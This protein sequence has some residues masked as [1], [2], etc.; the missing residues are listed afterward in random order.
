MIFGISFSMTIVTLGNKK[1]KPKITEIPL[2]NRRIEKY[3][4][5]HF[6]SAFIAEQKE[7]SLLRVFQQQSE[8]KSWDSNTGT[9]QPLKEKTK[10]VKYVKNNLNLS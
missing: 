1:Q 7:T 3:L 4:Q 8:P 6:P 2:V 9:R 5:K 10:E